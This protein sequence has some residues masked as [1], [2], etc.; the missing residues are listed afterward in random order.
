VIAAVTGDPRRAVELIDKAIELAPGHAPAHNNRGAALQELGQWEAAL[1]NYDR[2]ALLDRRYADP[3]Y[4][5]GNLFKDLGQWQSA[6]ASY[7]QAIL[8]NDSHAEAHCN[9]G[10]VLAALQNHAAALASYDRALAL[11]ANYVEAHYNRGNTLCEL[12]QWEAA[13]QSYD[14]A[15]ALEP[16]Y[17]AAYTN[18]AFV[19]RE[20]G[21]LDEALA[22]CDRALAIQPEFVPAHANRGGVLVA[23]NRP[24]EAL[25]CYDQALAI[26]PESASTHVNRGMTRLMLG[27]FAGGWADY[28]WRWRD[29][30]S[31]IIKEARHYPQPRWSGKEPLAGRTLLV[32]CEQGYGDTIQFCRFAKLVA[33]LGA[34]LIFEVPAALASLMRSLEGVAQWV[35][36]GDPL[37]PFDYHCPLL[38]LPLALNT[39]LETVPAPARYLSVGEDLRRRWQ[40]R[41]GERRGLRVGLAWSGGFRPGLPQLWSGNDR[42]NIP[43]RALAGL[44]HP[45]IE[46]YSLQK[47][48]PA[49][50]ELAQV[51]ASGWAGPKIHDLTGDIDDFADTAALVDQLDLVISVDTATAHL[52]GALGK[53]VWILNRFDHCWRWLSNRSD[54]PWYATARLYRQE[55]A[56]DWDGVLRRVGRDLHGLASVGRPGERE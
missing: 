43:L 8:L 54:S 28:E 7:E 32:Y 17:A 36:H 53:P 9:R 44:A 14:H 51:L 48:Q 37:P 39:R 10:M 20:M 41:L 52:A 18:R 2:A 15:V 42:R 34:R 40:L 50:S 16:R 3:H 6:L 1:A 35:V 24:E 29:Q 5:R 13:L 47:G 30:T 25:A 55:R 56:G 11:R 27:D 23:M 21:R 31:W 46:Y 19:L 45:G 12:R 38:S 26:A 22:S 4:N 33:A 49:E